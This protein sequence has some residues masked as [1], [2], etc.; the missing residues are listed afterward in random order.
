MSAKAISNLTDSGISNG[1]GVILRRAMI[2]AKG[3]D[4]EAIQRLMAACFGTARHGRTVRHLRLC[5]P[6]E[7]L[8]FVLEKDGYLVGSIRYWPIAVGGKTQLLLGPLAVDPSYKG[9]GFGKALLAH[10][11]AVAERLDYDFILI[12]GEPDYYPR[13]GFEP[14]GQGQ[15]IWPGFVEPERLQVKW[16]GGAGKDIIGSGPHAILPIMG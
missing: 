5:P 9:R 6:V 11:L 1:E 2:A 4:E 16:L 3:G 8:S 7:A 15:F 10:S 13:F 14:V 12:S